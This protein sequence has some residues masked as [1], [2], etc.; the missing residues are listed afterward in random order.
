LGA[1]IGEAVA[2][3]SLGRKAMIYGIIAQSL[4]DIDFVTSFYLNK[5]QELLAHRGFTH[6]ILFAM[7][8]T[9]LGAMAAHVGYK[10][11]VPLRKWIVLFGVN[12]FTHIFID[13]FNVYGTAWFEPFSHLR[14]S[15]N[16][17]Y[18]AD[19][20]FSVVPFVAAMALFFLHRQHARR[21]VWAG[22]GIGYVVIYLTYACINKLIVARDVEAALAKKGV[23]RS[24]YMLTPA[25][26]NTWLWYAVAKNDSG[27]LVG[28]RSVFD[29]GDTMD[30]NFF[31]RR[32][33]LL[34]SIADKESLLYL[35]RF[36][37]GYY[38]ADQWGDTT[39]FNDLRF[40][41]IV[42][43]HNPQER[44]VFH[45]YLT[46]S[47]ENDLVVQRGRFAKWDATTFRALLGRIKG[48]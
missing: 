26:L 29:Q 13:A 40:G 30:F 39:V 4:P 38:T 22:L 35:K 9:V 45:Y 48:K 43:W 18:V 12:I 32:E 2:G 17:L 19:P 21:K 24:D 5:P 23:S 20:F 11:Y 34:V 14:V 7:V 31:P 1:C 37:Q 33:Q 36:S 27:A 47:D 28:Y 25:P 15:F 41:Q 6:S 3:K 10:R 16:A 44:F 8:I 46:Q 42:G